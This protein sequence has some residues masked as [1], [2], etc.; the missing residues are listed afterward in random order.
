MTDFLTI[1]TIPVLVAECSF[2]EN[3]LEQNGSASRA[4]A[5][6]LRSTIRWEKR[7]WQVTTLPMLT[8]DANT[9]KAA[10]ALGAVVACAGNALGST[11]NCIVTVGDQTEIAAHAG[12]GLNF[13][14]VLTLNLRQV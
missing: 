7:S 14:R 10:I 2:K 9:L 3:P 8:A 4:Y 13:M 5:G 12:D 1:A 6:N 11:I